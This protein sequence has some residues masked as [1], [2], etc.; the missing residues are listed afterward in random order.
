M[1]YFFVAP[2]VAADNGNTKHFRLGRLYQQE[3]RLLVGAAGA[4]RV[5]VDNHFALR[6]RGDG[7]GRCKE[8]EK[9][10]SCPY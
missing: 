9:C 3:N 7:C 5:L 2:L 10:A 1:R 4:A 6:L 8:Q